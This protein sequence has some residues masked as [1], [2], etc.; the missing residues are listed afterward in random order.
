VGTLQAFQYSGPQ[1]CAGNRWIMDCGKSLSVQI[2]GS[3]L[4]AMGG[5]GVA[6]GLSMAGL[7]PVSAACGQQVQGIVTGAD[8]AVIK[9][10]A[11]DVLGQVKTKGNDTVEI[12]FG[13]QGTQCT[14]GYK[15]TQGTFLGLGQTAVATAAADGL[16]VAGAGAAAGGAAGLGMLG[17]AGVNATP[18]PEPGAVW[19]KKSG[20]TTAA[21]AGSLLLAVPAAALLLAAL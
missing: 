8:S 12:Y 13:G 10:P 11:F 21:A 16:G 18:S 5:S 2:M 20:A 7:S 9:F 3:G 14:A 17:M 15:L 6:G 1:A 4:A 19:S